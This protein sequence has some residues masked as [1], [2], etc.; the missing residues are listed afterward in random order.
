MPRELRS[1]FGFRLEGMQGI[2]GDR[3]E[4]VYAKRVRPGRLD[5]LDAS[6]YKSAM[7]ELHTATAQSR[8]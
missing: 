4:G 8:R 7:T 6:A 3:L 1:G 2:G 5:S